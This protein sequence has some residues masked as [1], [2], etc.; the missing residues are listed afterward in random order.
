M[1]R[2]LDLPD[3]RLEYVWHGPGPGEAPTLVF[4]HE[5][6]GSLSTWRDFPERLAEASG[7]G[8]LVY[9]RR[10][11]GGSDRAVLPRGV[12]FMHDEALVTLPRVL[13][14]LGVDEPIL[15]GESDGA[16]IALIAAAE[17][18]PGVRG[19]ILESPHVFVEPVCLRTIEFAIRAF[20]RGD[21]R[22]ALARHHTTDVE[23]TFR[24][25]A[26]AWLDP[27]FEAW[28]IEAD[29]PRIDAPVLAIQGIDDPYGT[30]RQVEK[31]AAG[32]AGFVKLLVLRDC[33]HSPHR[34]KPE[35]T[36]EAMASFLAQ[37]LR[38]ADAGANA[39]G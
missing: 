35:R 1:P 14:I 33:G 23:A 22:A 11:Y 28:N 26:A 4:L 16:S 3:H 39:T 37:E 27:E 21:L 9:S 25:W 20:D 10:G 31:I 30:L 32:C 7:C 13:E 18:V 24:G 8:A 12:R 36:L 2:R 19:L 38:R 6:L 5:G 29:L 34:E 15:V 17:S